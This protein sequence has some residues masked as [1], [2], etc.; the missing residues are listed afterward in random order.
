MFF[1]PVELELKGYLK[2]TLIRSSE[3]GCRKR[4]EKNGDT[5]EDVKFHEEFDN[6]LYFFIRGHLPCQ[7]ADEKSHRFLSE[8]FQIS[9]S[10]IDV[11]LR[12][13]VHNLP[14]IHQRHRTNDMTSGESLSVALS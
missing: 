14:Q 3:R 4:S 7:I 9:L 11:S 8:T 1:Y 13:F 2:V 12:F 5:L 10:K 6:E